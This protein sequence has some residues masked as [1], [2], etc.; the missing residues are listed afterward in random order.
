MKETNSKENPINSD[1]QIKA[2]LMPFTANLAARNY[3]QLDERPNLL[4]SW[5]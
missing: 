2:L 5:L 4:Y 1:D 3:Q